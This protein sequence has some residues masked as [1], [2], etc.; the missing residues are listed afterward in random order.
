MNEYLSLGNIYKTVGLKGEVRI[1]STSYFSADRYNNKELKFFLSKE[2]NEIVLETTAESYRQAGNFDV[3]KFKEINSIEEAEKY[4]GCE[5]LVL[6]D[7]NFLHKDQY[8]FDDLVG[9]EVYD[10]ENN[11]ILGKVIKVEEFPAQPALNVRKQ[12]GKSFYVPFI[13]QFIKKVD[14]ENKRIDIIVIKGLI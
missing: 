3:V 12:D 2:N 5:V 8:F 7:R 11:Q 6:K 9:C 13:N 10:S 4:L 1:Y 14:I